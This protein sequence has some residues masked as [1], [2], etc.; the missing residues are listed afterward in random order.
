MLILEGKH[1]IH[2]YLRNGAAT[3]LSALFPGPRLG[4]DDPMGNMQ[5]FCLGN[6]TELAGIKGLV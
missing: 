5:D 1:G 2:R 6:R 3:R 4:F